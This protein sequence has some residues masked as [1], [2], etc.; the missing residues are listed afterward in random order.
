MRKNE[1]GYEYYD[2]MHAL[3]TAL[4]DQALIAEVTQV[5][6]VGWWA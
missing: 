2:K 1:V 6:V 4:E 5:R 3:A